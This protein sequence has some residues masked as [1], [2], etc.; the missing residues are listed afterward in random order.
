MHPT[1]RATTGAPIGHIPKEVYRIGQ[2]SDAVILGE[3][4]DEERVPPGLSEQAGGEPFDPPAPAAGDGD[5]L[6]PVD[7]VGD[8]VAVNAAAGLELPELLS[9]TGVYGDRLP[10]RLPGEDK[11]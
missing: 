4:K 2:I 8:R 7:A 5:V 9:R 6:L 1:R 3:G 11:V 10:V